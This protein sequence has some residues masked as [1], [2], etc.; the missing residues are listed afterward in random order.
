MN[1]NLKSLIENGKLFG[2][3][4]IKDGDFFKFE[5]LSIEELEKLEED[6]IAYATQSMGRAVFQLGNDN[7]IINIKGVDSHLDNNE[8]GI[9]QLVGA[10]S[11][12]IVNDNKDYQDS[13]Y[14]INLVIF[15]G[16]RA[17]IRIRGASP[18][19]DLEIE[20]FVN[21]KMKEMGIKVPQIESINEFTN[22]VAMQLALPI[23]IPGSYDELDSDYRKENDDRKET[24]H[25]LYGDTYK[26]DTPNKLRAEKISEYFKRLGVFDSSEFKKIAKD[27]GFSVEDFV[28]YVDRVYSMG[29]RYGQAIRI[30][31]SPFRIS[32]LEYYVKNGDKKAIEDIIS[33]T[34]QT[35]LNVS[36]E[37]NFA[38]QMGINIAKLMNNGW[39]CENFVHRQD[40]TLTG[41]MCDDSYID[42]REKINELRQK[43]NSPGKIKAIE[44][45]YQRQFFTQFFLISSN[46]KVLQDE[47]ILR[48]KNKN[49][50]EN[51]IETFVDSF[52]DNI[53][54]LDISEKF[55]IDEN[56][57]KKHFY[58]LLNGEHNYSEEMASKTRPNGTIFD[59][60]I[61]FAHKDN[62]KFYNDISSKLHLDRNMFSTQKIVSQ[63]SEEI[64][65][66]SLSDE[67][68][69]VIEEQVK[70]IGNPNRTA[71]EK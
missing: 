66:I 12:H 53:N 54:F 19:E 57:V 63:V 49:D 51:L 56:Q 1:K 48:G 15:P 23:K 2:G 34:E 36:F 32:D 18:L 22:D 38:K 59:E 14:P 21:A 42:L 45:D 50:I 46:I 9:N 7:K 28:E 70:N 43:T 33:F 17:D 67:A 3:K 20:A 30:M 35:T 5:R 13:N 62:N 11:M 40:Y 41:E 8:I 31:E 61:L 55:G 58:D 26:E 60:E 6:E 37:E 29:Q 44:E 16:N 27:N 47:M 69:K 4:I 24:L 39:L 71:E 68:E 10:K 64:S 52:S 25:K 65:N